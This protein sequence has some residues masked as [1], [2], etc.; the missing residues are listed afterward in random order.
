MLLFVLLELQGFETIPSLPK[1][2]VDLAG[3]PRKS[4]SLR[5]NA[6]ETLN[7]PTSPHPKLNLQVPAT[8]HRGTLL[9]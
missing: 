4:Q 2:K 5:V 3:N 7:I 1:P 9:L 6:H 8:R